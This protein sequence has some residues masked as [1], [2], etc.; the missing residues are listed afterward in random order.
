LIDFAGTYTT[1]SY[2]INN[3]LLYAYGGGDGAT[4]LQVSS[5]AMTYSYNNIFENIRYCLIQT[6]STFANIHSDYNHYF[7]WNANWQFI[8]YNTYYTQAGTWQALGSG[9]DNNSN[10]VSV[11]AN[12]VNPGVAP[13]S[14]NNFGLKSTS[15]CI[16]AGTNVGLTETK[17]DIG[18]YPY[19]GRG[20]IVF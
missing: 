17:P 13:S 6:A 18:A 19:A 7:N 15:P 5:D 2:F 1:P 3:D 14:S 8:I 12:M 11:A 16:N 4:A 20:I 10:T 9:H